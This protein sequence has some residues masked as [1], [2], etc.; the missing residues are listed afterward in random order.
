VKPNSAVATLRWEKLAV[1]FR[2]AV[3]KDVALARIRARMRG[4]AQY[5][6]Q[7]WDEAA[8]PRSI[9]TWPNVFRSTG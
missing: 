8:P 6:W 2:V 5:N 4:E 1:P 9:A 7:G 3:S